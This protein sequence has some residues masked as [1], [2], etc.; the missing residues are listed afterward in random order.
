MKHLRWATGLLVLGGM[1][2]GCENDDDGVG[3]DAMETTF[4]VR[5]ENDRPAIRNQLSLNPL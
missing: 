1:V 4:E 3:P 2:A 5:I